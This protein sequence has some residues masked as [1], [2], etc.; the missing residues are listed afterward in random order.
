MD[1]FTSYIIDNITG[2]TVDNCKGFDN[3]DVF[4]YIITEDLSPNPQRGVIL[5]YGGIAPSDMLDEFGIDVLPEETRM[6]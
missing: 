2:F 1:G 3:E 6:L 5:G 4:D